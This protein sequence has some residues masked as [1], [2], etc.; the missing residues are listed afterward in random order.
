MYKLYKCSVVTDRYNYGFDIVDESRSKAE[1]KA[2]DYV[3]DMYEG[4]ELIGGG[5]EETDYIF[6]E[7]SI[8]LIERNENEVPYY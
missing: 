1:N 6:N 7:K 3:M 8:N 4:E 5:S 2:M